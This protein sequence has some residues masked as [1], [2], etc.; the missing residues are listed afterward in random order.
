[1]KSKSSAVSDLPLYL[2]LDENVSP[3]ISTWIPSV[4]PHWRVSYV[5]DVG[6]NGKSDA[7][8]FAWAQDH[9][10]VIVTFDEDFADRR[11]FPVGTHQGV[12]RLRIWPTTVEETQLAL[13]RLF[14][15][16]ADEEIVGSL[17]I[18]DAHR[19]RIRKQLQ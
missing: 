19:I 5:T 3:E 18:V 2:L 15:S 16:V 10:A 7:E 8:I 12:I 14:Q 11:M 13:G 1:M 6:L 4:K 9:Q 17:V